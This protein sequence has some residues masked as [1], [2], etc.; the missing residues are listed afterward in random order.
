MHRPPI[1][2]ALT[3]GLVATLLLPV[4]LAVVLGL[5][6]LLAAVGDESGARA[7]RRVALVAGA[8]WLVAVVTTTAASAVAVLERQEQPRL[9]PVKRM[10]PRRRD[11][12]L[13]G[14]GTQPGERSG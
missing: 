8:V 5:G 3:W 4:V 7:C 6:G 13:R 11:R 9:A 14:A 12:D 1:R 2:A 10:R